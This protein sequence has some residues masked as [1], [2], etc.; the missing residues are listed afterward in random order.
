MSEGN[1]I[2][3]KCVLI[4]VLFAV[5]AKADTTSSHRMSMKAFLNNE[6]PAV[7]VAGEITRG[8]RFKYHGK[9]VTG[10][11]I[12]PY[13][14]GQLFQRDIMFCGDVSDMFAGKTGLVLITYERVAHTEFCYDLLGV[15]SVTK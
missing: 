15:D 11:T 10:I 13:R 2:L 14:A 5:I 7:Y 9:M 4:L 1:K 12:I 6:N 3:I 8:A